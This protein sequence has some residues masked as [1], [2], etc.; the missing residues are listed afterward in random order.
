MCGFFGWFGTDRN[1]KKDVL[2]KISD[3]LTH[4][5][6]N[7]HGD[8]FDQNCMLGF[9]RLSILDLT[10]AGNQPMSSSN[11]RYHMVFNGEI[12]NY[13]SLH[14]YLDKDDFPLSSNSDSEVV[15]KLLIKK[16]VECLKYLNG[17]FSI[18]FYDSVEKKILLIR[19]RLGVKPLF[20][21]IQNETIYFASELPSL[22]NFGIPKEISLTSLNKYVRFGQINCP[23]TIYK[24]VYKLK[25][26]HYLELTLMNFNNFEQ[27]AWWKIPVYEDHIKN[28]S[29]WVNEVDELLYD[30]THLRLISD[31]PVGIFLSGGIDSSLVAHYA[32]IQSTYNKPIALSVKFDDKEFNEIDL[33]KIIAKEKG[34][35]L[36]TISVD[37]LSLKNLN[38]VNDN[39]GEPFSDSSLLN[40]Y[41]LSKEAKKYAT[42][43]LSGDGGD[44]AFG[45]YSEYLNASKYETLLPLVSSFAKCSYPYLSQIL[46]NDS[47]FKQIYSK[48][49]VGSKYIGTVIRNN[50]QEPLLVNLLNKEYQIDDTHILSGVLENWDSS[51]GLSLVKRMQHFDYYNYLESDILVK[52]DRATMANSIES[53]SP[54]L[55][56]RLIELAMRIPFKYNIQNGYG[57]QILRNLAKRYLPFEISKL[58]KKGFGLPYQSWLTKSLTET[59]VA[60]TKKNNHGYW[61][62]KVYMSI[63]NNANSTEYDYYSIFWRIWMFELWFERHMVK[64]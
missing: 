12:Y 3:S 23:D 40:Q 31:V 4:R 13:Q 34:L 43:F 60:L 61:N 20:F 10:S 42:V 17:M 18:V 35:E 14:Q 27:K 21:S 37:N 5:G 58:P 19:D 7:N 32:S 51:K 48:L 16:G 52:V 39:I 30:A 63:I 6:P 26:A 47:R 8:Y 11:G 2:S 41:L 9:R 53:R 29:K 24:N 50:Y 62:E 55:D 49:S 22:L 44:E 57:K 59:V 28:E 45:G 25:N 36:V 33:A 1:I 64:N 56:Y 46:N 15:F 54:F 38:K